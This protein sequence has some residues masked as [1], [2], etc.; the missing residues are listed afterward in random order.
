MT[1]ILQA[2][3]NTPLFCSGKIIRRSFIFAGDIIKNGEA[4]CLSVFVYASFAIPRSS[5]FF[6]FIRLFS[7]PSWVTRIRTTRGQW[8]RM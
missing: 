2:K 8:E 6:T 4:R 3:K 1:E 5:T 7:A